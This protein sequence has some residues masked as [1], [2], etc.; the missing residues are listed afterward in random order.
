MTR[1]H[2]VLGFVFV[3]L[4]GAYGCARGPAASAPDGRVA[5]AEAKVQRLEDDFR[6]AA[7]ARDSFRARLQ[8]AE[9]KQGQLQ[10][11]IDQGNA[12]LALERKEKDAVKGELKARTAE[13]DN[14]TAQYDVFRKNIRE[15]LGTA[16][17]ALN[18]PAAPTALV[19]TQ[20]PPPANNT[21]LRN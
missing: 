15:L 11:Q 21:S 16:E 3:T 9:E 8:A 10:R 2:K 17:S 20:A 12:T 14:L 18:G 13:R 4:F 6:A 7:T 1:S 5:A 19:G